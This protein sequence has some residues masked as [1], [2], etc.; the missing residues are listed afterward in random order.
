MPSQRYRQPPRSSL[1]ASDA[2]RERVA[3]F[4]RDQ[5]IEGRLTADELD[6]RV[7]HAYS[8]VTVG[9]LDRLVA[10]LP[11]PPGRP[12]FVR[13]ARRGPNP[14]PLVLAACFLLALPFMLGTALWVVFAVAVAVFA[15]VAVLAIALAPF[16]LAIGLI[17]MAARRRRPLGY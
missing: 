8:A 11:G 1:R 16:I 17:A 15:T 4:L 6:E 3:A 14:A 9:E 10:D 5:A 12:Q 7:G 13:P 2:E